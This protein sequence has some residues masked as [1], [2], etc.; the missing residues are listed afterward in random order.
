MPAALGLVF[1][2]EP[3]MHQ[4]IVPLA[5][6]H[7]NIA[8]PPAIAARGPAPRNKFLAAEGHAAI[9]AVA[10]LDPNFCLI[11]KHKHYDKHSDAGFSGQE[12]PLH[13]RKAS[14]RSRG[15]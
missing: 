5:G 2:I 13:T 1:R 7:P 10:R 12:C 6:F 15:C 3:E 9:A 11:D 14:T 8:A 4:R